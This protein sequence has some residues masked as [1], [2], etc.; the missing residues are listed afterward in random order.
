MAVAGIALPYGPSFKV[1]TVAGVVAMPASSF[2]FGRLAR[3]PYP[4]PALLSVATVAFL[5]DKNF[6]IYGGN[7]A[8]TMAGEFAFS[9]SLALA[10]AYLGVL[11]HVRHRHH[12]YRGRLH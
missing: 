8:S 10:I 9:I 2:L 5:F 3:L 7:I 11:V 6:T 12:R 1:V 4:T